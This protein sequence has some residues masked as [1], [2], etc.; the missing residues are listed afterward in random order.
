MSNE[1]QSSSLDLPFLPITL[2]KT[3]GCVLVTEANEESRSGRT[4][5]AVWILWTLVQNAKGMVSK[6]LSKPYIIFST[7]EAKTLTIPKRAS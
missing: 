4:E 5:T 2:I 3:E 6:P 7:F 1:F